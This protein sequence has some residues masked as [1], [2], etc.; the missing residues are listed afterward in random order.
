MLG[1]LAAGGFY[2]E[3]SSEDR[4]G[5]ATGSNAGAGAVMLPAVLDRPQ[6]LTHER[7]VSWHSRW[8]GTEG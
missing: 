4:G 8:A 1:R 6:I 5:A 3:P 2:V 7:G